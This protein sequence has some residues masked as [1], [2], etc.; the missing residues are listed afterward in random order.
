MKRI[1]LILLAAAVLTALSV[2]P[3]LK[4]SEALAFSGIDWEQPGD[5]KL[6]SCSRLVLKNGKRFPGCNGYI[7][8]SAI[9]IFMY[10]GRMA[11]RIEMI[12]FSQSPMEFLFFED[13]K[14]KKASS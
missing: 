7:T 10:N 14:Y 9:Y 3:A 6:F 8:D 5:V 4:G 12:D 1:L 13:G 2:T 11:F